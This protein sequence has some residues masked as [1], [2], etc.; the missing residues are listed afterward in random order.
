MKNNIPCEVI[1]DLF[2]SYI[3][4]LTT[5]ITNKEIAAHLNG[6]ES[7]RKVLYEMKN[8][9]AEPFDKEAVTEIDFLKKIRR[10]IK[11]AIVACVAVILVISLTVPTVFLAKNYFAD[12][13]LGAEAVECDVKVADNTLSVSAQSGIDGYAVRSL[14]FSYDDGRVNISCKTVKES[15]LFK[16]E[17]EK[18]FVAEGKIE[19]VAFGKRI[20]WADGTYVSKITADVFSTKHPYI[21]DMSKNSETAA[22]LNI[23]YLGNYISKLQTSHE[24]YDWTIIFLNS[25]SSARQAEMEK[26]LKNYAYVMLSMVDNLGSASFRY[27]IDKEEKLLTVTAKEATDFA[28]EDIKAVGQSISKLQRLMD[29][30]GLSENDYTTYESSLF[31]NYRNNVKIQLTN[32]AAGIGEISLLTYVDGE[33][34]S[35]QTAMLEDS[36]AAVNNYPVVFF[37][38]IPADLGCEK[39]DGEKEISFKLSLVDY[40]GEKHLIDEEYFFTVNAELGKTYCYELDGSSRLGYMLVEG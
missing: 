13:H 29:K 8:P 17:C 4:E 2:P 37:K 22:A 23:S 3:D 9:E 19:E 6:C 31:K 30:T 36:S 14:G 24:P 21:G 15:F 7:C 32:K 20:L 1:Q 12:A 26:Q 35:E 5:E 40:K 39:W 34:Y 27:V 10:K 16:G 28:D 25:Y 33:L 18:E 38:L 11:K